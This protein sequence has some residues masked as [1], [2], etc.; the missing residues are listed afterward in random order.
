MLVKINL[1]SG[2]SSINGLGQLTFEA[3][4]HYLGASWDPADWRCD[5][6][7]A[8]FRL[9]D[10]KDGRCPRCGGY[11]RQKDAL[12]LVAERRRMSEAELRREMGVRQLAQR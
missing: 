1:W 6:C 12:R 10:Q 9:L 2:P 5:E 3:T 4:R 11:T 8:R 7:P